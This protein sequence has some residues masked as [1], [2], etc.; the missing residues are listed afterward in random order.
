M[1][2]EVLIWVLPNMEW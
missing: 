2:D 1:T